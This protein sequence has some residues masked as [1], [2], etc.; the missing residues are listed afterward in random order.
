MTAGCL[1][2]YESDQLCLNHADYKTYMT[3]I[4][5]DRAV[6]VNKLKVNPPLFGSLKLTKTVSADSELTDDDK[7]KYFAFDI[8]LTDE[9]GDLLS[10]N[11]KYGGTSFVDG[12]YRTALKHGE[13][14]T[15]T[16]IPEGYHYSIEE[17]QTEGYIPDPDNDTEGVIPADDVE[18]VDFVN[19]RLSSAIK[20]QSATF[21]VKKVGQ[22]NTNNTLLNFR[23]YFSGLEPNTQYSF[24]TVGTYPTTRYFSSDEEGEAVV[25]FKL[26]VYSSGVYDYTDYYRV[27]N[28]VQFNVLTGCHYRIE[29]LAGAYIASYSVSA[30]G[31][32]AFVEK[33]S[34]A[35][36]GLNTV[37]STAEETLDNNENAVITFTNDYPYYQNLIIKKSVNKNGYTGTEYDNY[38]YPFSVELNDL[39]PGMSLTVS[40]TS[41]EADENGYLLIPLTLKSNASVTLRVPVGTHYIITEP[42]GAFY[43]ASYSIT[44][45]STCIQ[46]SDSNEALNTELSTYSEDKGE[47]VERN[48]NATVT[49]TNTL[50]PG[51]APVTLSLTKLLDLSEAENGGLNS[52]NERFEF[53]IIVYDPDFADSYDGTYTLSHPNLDPVVRHAA[54]ST[55]DEQTCKLTITLTQDQTALIGGFLDGMEYEIVEK[56][57]FGY[58]PSY[59][60]T[61]SGKTGGQTIDLG[62][63]TLSQSNVSLSTGRKTIDGDDGDIEAVFTNKYKAVTLYILP[64]AGMSDFRWYYPVVFLMLC[65]TAGCCLFV[66]CRRRTK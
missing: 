66:N 13:S 49:F 12:R 47:A 57:V 63:D 51:N 61:G 28:E 18:E 40:G 43:K 1:A 16:E 58:S 59:I 53:D 14:V 42:A 26:T 55:V 19:N 56:A 45:Y 8:I 24:R 27:Y 15:I 46:A 33:E 38:A 5:N 11:K 7:A 44:N 54:L 29:E 21:N 50:D 9:N 41:Y 4:D 39:I 37:L 52:A 62:S 22:N 25:P 20:P 2:D 17:I 65:L 6:I 3:P 32:G 64:S 10:G 35:N 34:D 23:A 36:T 48:E 31:T 60:L 30:E